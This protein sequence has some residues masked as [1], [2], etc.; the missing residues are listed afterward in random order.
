MFR[1]FSR[2]I[3][4]RGPPVSINWDV[5]IQARGSVPKMRCGSEDWDNS[6][7]I[8]TPGKRVRRRKLGLPDIG[9]TLAQRSPSE[10][11]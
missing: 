8:D 11:P 3:L 7:G 6:V 4:D 10:A 1:V 5:D 2:T 9:Y